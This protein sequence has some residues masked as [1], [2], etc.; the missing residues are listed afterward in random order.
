[1]SLAALILGLGLAAPSFS[2]PPELESQNG[3]VLLEW[4]EDEAASTYEVEQSGTGVVA[5]TA[6]TGRLP[7][8][9][10]SG[11]LPGTYR[12]R[13]RAQDESGAWSE[14]SPAVEVSVAYHP[15][16]GV[17]VSLGL[18]AAVFLLTAGFVVSRVRAREDD[19]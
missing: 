5:R 15:M 6:Y 4:Q 3:S 11:M 17:F 8:A 2:G 18:G 19:A 13:V 12:F 7:S 16:G 10:V 1:M 9:H 14:W